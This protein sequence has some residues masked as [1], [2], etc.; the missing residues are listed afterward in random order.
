MGSVERKGVYK[1]R[2]CFILL[3]ITVSL[4]IAGCGGRGYPTAQIQGRV[5][6]GGQPVARGS[7]TFTPLQ[8]GRGPGTSA[9]VESGRY[10]VE[11]APQGRVRVDFQA[12]KDTGR[13]ETQ[14]GKTYP[15][16]VNLIPDKYRA[17]L[18]IEV[19]GDS[20]TQDFSL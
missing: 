11:N 8:P 9:S 7:I 12:L 15:V 13:T 5:T 17:G 4:V 19:A 3:G 16:M 1:M 10:T 20:K 6:V 14:F 18:E 2:T